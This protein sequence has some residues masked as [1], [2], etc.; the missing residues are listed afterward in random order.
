M[1][2][3]SGVPL[4]R[5]AVRRYARAAVDSAPDRT[6]PLARPPVSRRLA[7]AMNRARLTGAAPGAPVVQ[8][9]ELH[10]LGLLHEIFHHLVER[11]E[12]EVRPAAFSDALAAVARERGD[13]QT[14]RL[15]RTFERQFPGSPESRD[16]A[17]E[18]LLLTWLANANPAA[19]PLRELFDDRPLER[20]T[21]YRPTLATLEEFFAAEPAFGPDGETLVELLRAPA[22]ASPTSLAGQL[23]YIRDRWA[24]LLGGLLDRLLVA[25]DVI[26]EEERAL[27]LRFGGGAAGGGFGGVAQPPALW[28]RDDEP[29]RFS[30]DSEWMPRVVLIAKSTYVWLDQMSRRVGGDIRTLDA[31]PD[32]ELDRLASWG[33]TGLWLIGLW[34]RS[35]ASERIKRLRGNPDAVASAY[36]LDDYR[37]AD[38]LGGEGAY[39][40]L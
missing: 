11:Y 33:V 25:L 15:L 21:D 6:V 35:A 13:R 22:A 36:S 24:P 31:I 14:Q 17:L 12:S 1:T 23:R 26:S 8:S 38:D 20:E 4:E 28:G 18:E 2:R 29:E 39:E 7:A 10:A 32:Q 9:G 30:T 34:Q 3:R 27:H 40:S 5:A 19:E 16:L 37:I